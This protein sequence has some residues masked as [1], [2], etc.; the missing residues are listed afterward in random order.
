MW[1][2]IHRRHLARFGSATFVMLASVIVAVAA[3]PAV[4]AADPDARAHQP[5]RF[6]AETG[7]VYQVA[8]P[9]QSWPGVDDFGC[10]PTEQHPRPVLLL[11]G[12]GANGVNNWG[13]FAPA[14]LN[15]GYCVFAP[16]YGASPLFP[17]IGAATRM[18]DHV[19]EVAA[20]A[21]RVLEATGAKQ[22]DVVG[23][24]QGATVGLHLATVARPG[25][26]SRVV[27]LAGFAGGSPSAMPGMSSLGEVMDLDALG[28]ENSHL[29]PEGP[30]L[31][32]FP[33]LLDINRYS[34]A[35]RDLYAGGHPFDESTGYTLIASARDG[36][37]PP[38]L[39]FPPGE[40]EGVSMHVLQDTC[41]VNGADHVS[42]YADPQT[43]D[44]TLNALDP[45]NAVGPRCTA[46]MPVIGMPGEV[47]PRG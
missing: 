21:D 29:I 1:S 14:L 15:E 4:T 6:T 42:M 32:P 33:S 43:L 24:S 23:H 38:G 41:P 37:V 3:A 27:S 12:T 45:E 40:F 20:Y 18:G 30:L 7:G 47:P 31:I 44:L 22:V 5:V 19:T 16:T 17:G 46:T 9:G 11:H 34:P 28:A 25:K 26:V 35:S 2:V 36:L 13:T 39:S 10:R 8:H